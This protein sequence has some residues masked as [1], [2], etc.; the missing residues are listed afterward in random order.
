MD[1]GHG[2]LESGLVYGLD[3]YGTVCVVCS[4]GLVH[5]PRVSNRA[6]NCLLQLLIRF[7]TYIG[8]ITTFLPAK[9]STY[10]HVGIGTFF[11]P[12]IKRAVVS[13]EPRTSEPCCLLLV[14]CCADECQAL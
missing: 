12:A 6:D 9:S 11:L 4:I 1:G 7:L 13:D 8:I 3:V 14:C 10:G 2:G 5:S